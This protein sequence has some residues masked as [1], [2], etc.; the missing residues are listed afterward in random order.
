VSMDDDAIGADLVVAARFASTG[1]NAPSANP[2]E[3]AGF[4]S[5]FEDAASARI[6][7]GL[8]SA[9]T[10]VSGGIASLA[11]EAPFATTGE[12][13]PSARSAAQSASTAKRLVIVTSAALG[14]FGIDRDRKKPN[15]FN[16]IRP[17]N[18]NSNSSSSSSSNPETAPA[19]GLIVASSPFPSASRS[20]C[21]FVLCRV[22]ANQFATSPTRTFL[23]TIAEIALLDRSTR[24]C[25]I[26]CGKRSANVVKS[27]NSRPAC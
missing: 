20:P 27:S 19:C 25:H 12:F 1:V 13:A 18:S 16:G 4:A 17:S 6:V 15:T 11:R 10:A 21:D 3:A 8:R 22:A 24:A 5:T 7:V 14:T 26:G 23:V 2:A 9:C